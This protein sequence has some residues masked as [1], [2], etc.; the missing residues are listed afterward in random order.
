M[1]P[2]RSQILRQAED[3]AQAARYK[4]IWKLTYGSCNFI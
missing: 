3:A 2:Q 1:F 4:L